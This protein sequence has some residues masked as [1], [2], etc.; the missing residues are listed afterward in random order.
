MKVTSHTRS[1]TCFTP[2]ACPA[3]SCL[4]LFSTVV[5][6]L[7]FG[8]GAVRGRRDRL[9]QPFDVLSP[10]DPAHARPALFEGGPDLSFVVHLDPNEHEP[11]ISR[12]QGLLR[13]L[14]HRA[15]K[16]VAMRERAP[17]NNQ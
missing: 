8:K 1:P 2:T 7:C 17:R 9:V 10:P 11:D 14:D 12:G 3:K 4:R 5:G 6:R 16:T 15:I 13:C